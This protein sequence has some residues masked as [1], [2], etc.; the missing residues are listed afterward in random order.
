[1]TLRRHNILTRVVAVMSVACWHYWRPC[2]SSSPVHRCSSLNNHC[3]F[4]Y[5][6][7]LFTRVAVVHRR[8]DWTIC[9]TPASPTTT[10]RSGA[11]STASDEPAATSRVRLGPESSGVCGCFDC[12]RRVPKTASLVSARAVAGHQASCSRVVVGEVATVPVPG[13]HRVLRG[14]CVAYLARLFPVS[15]RRCRAMLRRLP[16]IRGAHRWELAQSDGFGVPFTVL[17]GR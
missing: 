5:G 16:A 12:C 2:N 9:S 3:P 4:C 15:Q 17:C 14:A 6:G 11:A 7:T 8:R 13:W 10:T 1:M